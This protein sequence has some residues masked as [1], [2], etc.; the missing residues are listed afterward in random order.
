MGTNDPSIAQPREPSLT[1][2]NNPR[3][4]APEHLTRL[5]ASIAMAD[6]LAVIIDVDALGRSALEN[7]DRGLTLALDALS[8]VGVQVVVAARVAMDRAVAL[9]RGIP[10]A[11]VLD[12][13][14]AVPLMREREPSLRRIVISN[15]PELLATLRPGDRGFTLGNVRN[16]SHGFMSGESALRLVLWWLVSVRARASMARRP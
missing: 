5:L 8:Y 3:L 9:Q 10:R 12:T 14:G 4:C 6:R 1:V 16:T 7:G 13:A 11:G 15:D 2:S